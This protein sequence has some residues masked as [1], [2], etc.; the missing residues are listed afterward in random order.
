MVTAR[1]GTRARVRNAL[2][3]RRVI[4]LVDQ[5]T[6]SFSNLLLSVAIAHTVSASAFGVYAIASTIYL[7]CLGALRA[8]V[9]EPLLILRDSAHFNQGA[10]DNRAAGMGLMAGALVALPLLVTLLV[11]SL[12][13]LAALGALIPALLWLDM[14]RYVCFARREPRYALLAD[15]I[16][17][18]AQ[19]VFGSIVFAAHT[20]S[21]SVWI[22]SWATAALVSA[23]AMSLVLRLPPIVSGTLS[24]AK[25]RSRVS[26]QMFADFVVYMG[27]QQLVVLLLPLVSGLAILGGLKAAQVAAGP[28]QIALAAANVI[29]IPSIARLTR[30]KKFDRVAERGLQLSAAAFGFGLL[31][32]AVIVAMPVSVGSAIFGAS[33]STGSSFAVYVGIQATLSGVAQGGVVVLRGTGST[34]RGLVVRLWMTPLNIAL[35]LVGAAVWGVTGLGVALVAVAAMAS[36]VW[37]GAG[38]RTVREHKARVDQHA[39]SAVVQ[40]AAMLAVGGTDF[41]AELATEGAVLSSVE[42]EIP[43]ATEA[44]P[45]E[46]PE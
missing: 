32:T 14:L 11:P 1:R 43:P 28:L 20:G 4:S 41:E 10:V 8:L 17:L 36:A 7:F 25:E 45:A 38:W 15:A 37:W 35:P 30:Q 31:Y 26:K 6:A 23:I 19:V 13:P 44:E 2:S 39:E 46:D 12:R 5:A 29:A 27:G 40:H 3:D 33:W 24:W 9:G 42:G 34:G 16:W 22:I 18:L 21:V